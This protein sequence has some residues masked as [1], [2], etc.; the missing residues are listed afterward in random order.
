MYLLQGAGGKPGDYQ[1][2]VWENPVPRRD[3]FPGGFA[4]KLAPPVTHTS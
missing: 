4:S 3:R 2:A 1:D